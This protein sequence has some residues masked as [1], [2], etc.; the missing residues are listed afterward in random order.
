M[1]KSMSEEELSMGIMAPMGLYNYMQ[2]HIEWMKIKNYSKATI[3][4]YKI[5]ANVFISWCDQRSLITPAEI[6][7]SILERYQRYLFHYR[8]KDGQPLS[9]AS[10]AGRLVTVRTLFKWL[11]KENYILYNPASE[12]ELPKIEKRLPKAILNE[13]E[14]EQVLRQPD[15][16][17]ALGIRDRAVLETFYSTGIRRQELINLGIYDI[18]ADRGILTVRQGKGSKDR[19][20]PIGDRALKWI[21]KYKYEVRPELQCGQDEQTL[22]LNCYGEKMKVNGMTVIVAR[23]IDKANIGKKGSCHLFRHSMAT[24][25][26]EN[27]ADIRYVQAMLGHV[28]LETTEIYTQVSI[29][30]LKEVHTLTHPAKDHRTKRID[31]EE[32]EPTKQD[33]INQLEKEAQEEL[34]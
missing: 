14:I 34:D 5:N 25:M 12:I 13:K 1:K 10:Q 29:K 8:K 31:I 22:F 2:K 16:T 20:I 30:R 28:K 21:E 7:K 24:H 33:V 9:T 4:R 26:L 27:G 32:P 3:R 19:V 23:Y 17:T 6:T 18:D 15:L 11:A